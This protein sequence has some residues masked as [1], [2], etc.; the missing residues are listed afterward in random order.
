MYALESSCRART[1][2]NVRCY[3]EIF[4]LLKPGGILVIIEALLHQSSPLPTFIDGIYRSWCRNWAVTELGEQS[5]V[6]G[7]LRQLSFSEIELRE[8]SWRIAPSAL[9][10]PVVATAF[11][12]R[13]L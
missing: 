8:I 1:Q 9:H 5:A 13:E 4:H 6:L 2:T 12:L 7:A 11:T 3:G 10:I